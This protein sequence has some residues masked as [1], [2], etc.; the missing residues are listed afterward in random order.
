MLLPQHTYQPGNDQEIEDCLLSGEKKM[1]I[2]KKKFVASML[3][4][5][6]VPEMKKA[7]FNQ[8]CG[9]FFIGQGGMVLN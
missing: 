9:F 3:S 2:K 1:K 7:L 6:R 4:N 5:L 8:M